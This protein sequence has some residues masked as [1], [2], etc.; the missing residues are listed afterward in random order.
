MGGRVK[1][2]EGAFP[3]TKEKKRTVEGTSGW[4]RNEAPQQEAPLL[5]NSLGVHLGFPPGRADRMLGDAHEGF[6]VKP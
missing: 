4:R 1:E 3:G 2:K 6:S 5:P